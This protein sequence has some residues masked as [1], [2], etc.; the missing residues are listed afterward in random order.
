MKTTFPLRIIFC[1]PQSTLALETLN[2]YIINNFIIQFLQNIICSLKAPETRTI[3]GK[4][5]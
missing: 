5:S 1:E 3:A 2:I 4:T